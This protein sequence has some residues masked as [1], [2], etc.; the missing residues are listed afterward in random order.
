MSKE[1]KILLAALTG[2]GA[3]IIDVTLLCVL[4]N[5][6]PGYNQ[7]RNTISSLGASISPVSNIISIWWIILGVLFII[8]GLGFR[9]SFGKENKFVTL[10]MWAII[11][12]GLGEQI[13]S[14]AFKANYVG[15]SL[16]LSGY[17]HD[18]LGSFGIIAILAL[19]L[20]MNKI[21]PG[22]GENHAFRIFSQIIFGIL[23]F[24]IILFTFRFL[25]N[26]SSPILDNKGL[27]QRLFVIIIYVYFIA[28]AF[29]MIKNRKATIQKH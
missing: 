10:A 19:P 16:T 23:S 7:T 28:I 21:V 29:I 22:P 13:G 5:F 20:L 26:F 2:I 3:C 9:L 12:Y 17:I 4:G 15:N 18:T 8:F 1:K 25:K 24:F 27:W 6:Y 14:G 11:I